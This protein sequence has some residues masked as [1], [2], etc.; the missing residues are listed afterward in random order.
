MATK[1]KVTN[2]QEL[3]PSLFPEETLQRDQLL[4]VRSRMI[5]VARFS[6]G[7]TQE[8]LAER[9]GL[10]QAVIHR[11][12]T[13]K[14]YPSDLYINKISEATRYPITF[15]DEDINVLPPYPIY[16]RR[17]KNVSNTILQHVEYG[18]FVKKHIVK[19][20]LEAVDLPKKMM[21]KRVG[22]KVTPQDIAQYVRLR[23]NIPRGPIDNLVRR[24]EAAGI[25]ILLIDI[26]VDGVDGLVLPDEDDL[27]VICI[28]KSLAPDRMRFTLAHELGHLVMHTD[29]YF[30]NADDDYDKE[31]DS[32]AQEFLMPTA[33][34]STHLSKKL[35]MSQLGALKGY[36]KVSMAA[37]IR[38]AFDSGAIDKARYTSLNVQ[39]SQHGYRKQE[40]SMGLT[41][42][43]PSV[44]SIVVDLYQKELKYTFNDIADLVKIHPEEL[45]ELYKPN[46]SPFKIIRNET[47]K[48]DTMSEKFNE[49]LRQ[50]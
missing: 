16:Y 11:L 50:S 6:R 33:D 47:P 14:V 26:D 28:N 35:P 19:R 22:P 2:D 4:T 21:Y 45:M 15:F 13:Q 30:P 1:A 20:L 23:W 48:H 49:R 37:I 46:L 42:E 9:T 39:L 3:N 10:Q 40:P 8:E 41:P 12:E 5:Q 32:F 29:D 31:A 25:I 24:L 34:I 18:L 44:I 38:K 36:W 43:T 27:P 7:L 17:R